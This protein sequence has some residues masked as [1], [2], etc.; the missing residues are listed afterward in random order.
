VD[1]R[2]VGQFKGMRWR[3]SDI[4]KDNTRYAIEGLKKDEW[5]T[6]ESR[7]IEARTDWAMDGPTPD[8]DVLG[9]IKILFEGPLEARLLLDDL[10]IRE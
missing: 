10:E 7:A 3:S 8:G 4:L 5:I 9:N 1:G 6:V 2:L